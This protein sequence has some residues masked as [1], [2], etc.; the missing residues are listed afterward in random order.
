M[1]ANI[2]FLGYDRL[3]LQA[4]VSSI[5]IVMRRLPIWLCVCRKVMA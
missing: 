2:S 3:G 5:A 4:N 1:L